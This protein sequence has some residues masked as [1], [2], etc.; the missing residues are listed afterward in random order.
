MGLPPGT[1]GPDAAQTD[2]QSQLY[3]IDFDMMVKGNICKRRRETVRQYVITVKCAT[4]LVTS[5]DVVDR[6]IYEALLAAGVIRPPSPAPPSDA[7]KTDSDDAP[8]PDDATE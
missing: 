1:L 8:V 3:R 4:R 6:E 2:P 5:G 7:D